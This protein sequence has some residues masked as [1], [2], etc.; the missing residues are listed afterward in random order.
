M[1]TTSVVLGFTPG[2]S[3]PC[4]W[5][6]RSRW[7]GVIDWGC[8]VLESWWFNKSPKN[9]IWEEMIFGEFFLFFLW[10]FCFLLKNLQWEHVCFS[11]RPWKASIQTR[12]LLLFVGLW[13]GTSGWCH[14]KQLDCLQGHATK[15]MP[16]QKQGIWRWISYCHVSFSRESM[17]QCSKTVKGF[18]LVQCIW[19][20][21]CLLAGPAGVPQFHG[22]WM[23]GV[24]IVESIW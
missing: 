16:R 18:L 5:K 17:S 4:C 12:A 15:L 9:M 20:C 14:K 13:Y 6:M 8:Q 3:R 10:M 2:S 11:H 23:A 21:Y 22:T 1:P 7:K 19:N 24:S